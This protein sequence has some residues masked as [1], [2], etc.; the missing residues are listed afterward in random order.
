MINGIQQVNTQC[1]SFLCCE[2]G[3]RI[4]L[5]SCVYFVKLLRELQYFHVFYLSN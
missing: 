5:F 4:A 3:V 2:T 1:N